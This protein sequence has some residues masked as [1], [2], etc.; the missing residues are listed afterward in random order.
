MN[1]VTF[2]LSNCCV[3]PI[4]STAADGTP[5][6]GAKI[7]MP[8]AVSLSL[9]PAGNAQQVYADNGVY[10]SA[11]PNNGYSG[12]FNFY[13]LP[14]EFREKILKETKDAKDVWIE[15]KSAI[16]SE[17]A[18]G[19]QFE[20][21]ENASRRVFY[22]VSCGR[23]GQASS[24]N[25]ESVTANTL[26]LDLTVMAR[27]SDGA[28]KAKCDADSKAYSTFFGDAPYEKSTTA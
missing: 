14:D 24:T 27:I 13:T 7:D 26:S 22:R 16:P 18:F 5:T 9:D 28:V 4:T 23:I 20:G 2:G 25:E 12:S 10:Y 15:D 3:W 21:D 11:T 1:R 19:C 8:G 17:F 6:Y